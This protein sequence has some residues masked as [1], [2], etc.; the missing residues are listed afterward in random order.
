MEIPLR[1]A[2]GNVSPVGVRFHLP[3]FGKEVNHGT[4]ELTGVDSVVGCDEW[5]AEVVD[6]VLHEF[7]EFFVV[8]HE[9]VGVAKV[10]G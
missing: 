10:N 8:V 6:G 4:F 5:I 7:V 2:G 3:Q 1:A 9:V